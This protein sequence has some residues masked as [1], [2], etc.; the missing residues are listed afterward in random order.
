MAETVATREGA[1]AP[2]LRLAAAPPRRS[3]WRRAGP[4]FW[5]GLALL[6][7]VLVVAVG[8][9]VLAPYDPI[10]QDFAAV[11]KPPGPDHLFGTDNFGRD[12]LSR[13]L[14]GTRI[15]LQIGLLSVVFP[16]LIGSAIGCITGFFGG[17][18]DMV[19]G[20]I[21]DVVMAFPFLILVIAIMAMLGPGLTNLYIAVAMVGWISYHRIVRGDTLVTRELDYVTAGRTLGATDAH[22]IRRHVL[23]NV[24]TPAIVYAM[25]HIVT[26]ILLGASLSFLGL[27]VAPPTPEWG[28]MIAESRPFMLVAWWIP[29]F[30][31]LALV[32]TG[33]AF[34]LLGDGL[35]D[36]L[37]PELGR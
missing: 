19:V 36:L 28:A 4:S 2:D 17:W 18:L 1:L 5:W 21:V 9:P 33:L 22:L 25:T 8:A 14:W 6:V 35:A 11:L 24:I 7:L 16:F 37:R 20:R 31:G 32:V 12:I 26:A 29:T 15:D 10:T 23:P 30:P 3:A 34:S 27:G 13:V